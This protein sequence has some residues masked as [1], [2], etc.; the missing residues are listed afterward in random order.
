MDDPRV[1]TWCLIELTYPSALL[2]IAVQNADSDTFHEINSA[3][4]HGD[5]TTRSGAILRAWAEGW[6]VQINSYSVRPPI[7]TWQGDP[8]CEVH[9]RGIALRELE[10]QTVR[11]AQW[12]PRRASRG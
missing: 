1:C 12:G 5:L 9:L 3:A 7:T 8:V 4:I 6:H 10:P 11:M 2:K